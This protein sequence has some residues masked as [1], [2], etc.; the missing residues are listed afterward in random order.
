M[1]EKV[2][3]NSN[4]R[5]SLR[6]VRTLRFSRAALYAIAT[7][8]KNLKRKN[9]MR[10]LYTLI[11]L[12]SILNS[13]SAQLE[14]SASTDKNIYHYGDYIYPRITATNSGSLPDTLG[15]TSS[16]QVNY[17]IDSVSFMHH[18]SIIIMC[19]EV[20]TECIIAPNDSTVW[21]GVQNPLWGY[22]VSIATLGIGKHAV[23]GEVFGYWLSDTL[24]I[25][26][27]ALTDVRSTDKI[28]QDY[29]LQNNYPNP[30]NPSTTINYQ[31]PK[32]SYITLKVFD[33]LGR[34]VATL[35]NRVEEQGYKS[36]NFDASKLSSGIYYY[37]L[38]A[39]NYAETKK[40]LLLR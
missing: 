18:D 22:P 25:E 12:L 36:V 13:L 8:I 23:V 29:L 20:F 34:E 10:T 4:V 27:E 35:V 40:L 19:A 33:V 17:Y 26:V 21:G 38:Q 2:G 16:C 31:L 24:W 14:Y 9:K 1:S 37:R 28:P 6:L 5:P 30:F 15:F 3:K 32:Q 7:S 39:G 11:F